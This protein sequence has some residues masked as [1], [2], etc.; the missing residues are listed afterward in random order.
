MLGDTLEQF[1]IASTIPVMLVVGASDTIIASIMFC[2]AFIKRIDWWLRPAAAW[3]T[4]IAI[5]TRYRF[6]ITKPGPER[7]IIPIYALG[8]KNSDAAY[9]SAVATVHC[10]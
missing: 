7:P 8:G 3:P 2:A 10:G 4:I 9:Q 5:D 1:L 6:V